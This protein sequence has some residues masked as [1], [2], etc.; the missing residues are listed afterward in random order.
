M[1]T[2]IETLEL[3]RASI[4]ELIEAAAAEVERDRLERERQSAQAIEYANSAA[5]ISA[6]YLQGREDERRRV[7]ALLEAQREALGRGGVNSLSLATLSRSILE[8]E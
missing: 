6:A 1:S 5:N 8:A 7:L 4:N 2:A 3:T